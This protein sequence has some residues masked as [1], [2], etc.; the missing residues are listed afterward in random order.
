MLTMVWTK[1]SF[2]SGSDDNCVEVR[3]VEG[4]VETRNSNNPHGPSVT[5]TTAEWAAFLDG[6][7]AAEFD[8]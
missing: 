7:K 8:V 5:Y 6:V 4:G 3:L 1:S 2:S